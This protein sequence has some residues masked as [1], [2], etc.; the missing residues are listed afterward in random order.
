MVHP[1]T[2]QPILTYFSEIIHLEGHLN[3]CIGSKVTA[4]LLNVWI[5]PT[6]T[7]GVATG[8]VC[9]AAYAA[10]FFLYIWSRSRSSSTIYLLH[11][12]G[13]QPFKFI[14]CFIIA[15]FPHPPPPA[16]SHHQPQPIIQFHIFKLTFDGS[17]EIKTLADKV[18]CRRNAQQT[19]KRK[20]SRHT[21][22]LNKHI[23]MIALVFIRE[24]I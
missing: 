23:I 20:L 12:M 21:P 24:I 11:N 3:R 8:M 18:L 15:Q 16:P 22:V 7:G 10:G 5:L 14:S 13:Y 19:Q 6:A 17:F 1:V 2:K 9:P 4:I